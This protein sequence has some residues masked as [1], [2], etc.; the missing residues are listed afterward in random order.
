MFIEIIGYLTKLRSFR[1]ET[2]PVRMIVETND[3][4]P[5]GALRMKK[6]TGL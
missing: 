3:Y 6:K 5:N 4:A 2:R 1:S